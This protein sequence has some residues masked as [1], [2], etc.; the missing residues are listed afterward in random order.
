MI[1]FNVM[2]A[3]RMGIG[4][5]IPCL[6][7]F[8]MGRQVSWDSNCCVYISWVAVSYSQ[9]LVNFWEWGLEFFSVGPFPCYIKVDFQISEKCPV[10]VFFGKVAGLS[11][12]A[13]LATTCR[14]HTVLVLY[15]RLPL[16]LV[17][18]D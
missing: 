2:A 5:L 15:L 1:I 9:A 14:C 11:V 13:M 3:R 10:L 8:A 4:S 18:R 12:V 17:I 7:S 16:G 6:V